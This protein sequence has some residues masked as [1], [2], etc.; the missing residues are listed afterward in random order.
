M[1]DQL[2]KRKFLKKYSKYKNVDKIPTL[3]IEEIIKKLKGK[4]IHLYNKFMLLEKENPKYNYLKYTEFGAKKNE[5]F[6]INNFFK[7]DLKNWEYQKSFLSEEENKQF[8][9]FE[10]YKTV[11]SSSEWFRWIE[12]DR[13]DKKKNIVYGSIGGLFF[14]L[15]SYLYEKIDNYID[16]KIPNNY[17][18]EKYNAPLF[19]KDKKNSKYFT[20]AESEIRAFGKEKELENV[21]KIV[22][23]K[24]NYF[25]SIILD[26][27]KPYE[28]ITFTKDEKNK[29]EDTPTRVIL[30]GGKEAA[31]K[32]NFKTFFE[33]VYKLE[34]PFGIVNN[35]KKDLW[36]NIKKDI[37]E[38]INKELNK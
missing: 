29:Y 33:D 36:K 18:K 3:K 10:S 13:F 26:K 1:K 28:G 17:F 5:I 35:L 38:I 32:I 4:D 15:H 30:I 27:I 9:I 2:L 11:F 7:W 21:R 23:E 24:D 20:M 14:F 22:R 31:K 25:S 6:K 16:K 37:K 8:F 19:S 12:E 34:Q